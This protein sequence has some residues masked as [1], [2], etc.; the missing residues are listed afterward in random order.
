MVVRNSWSAGPQ[1]LLHL[2]NV[3]R[4]RKVFWIV[5]LLGRSFWSDKSSQSCIASNANTRTSWVGLQRGYDFR[6][7]IYSAYPHNAD[8]LYWVLEPYTSSKISERSKSRVL[9]VEARIWKV[10]RLPPTLL[11]R[12]SQLLLQILANPTRHSEQYLF[13]AEWALHLREK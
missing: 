1:L 6:T 10:S 5:K 7:P 2:F 12:L 4:S 9:Q 3:K 8:Q 13:A 11:Q